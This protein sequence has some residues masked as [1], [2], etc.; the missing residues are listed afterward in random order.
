ML[1]GSDRMLTLAISRR[2]CRRGG[3]TLQSNAAREDRVRELGGGSVYDPAGTVQHEFHG[4]EIGQTETAPNLD[5]PRRDQARRD[6]GD[7]KP[8]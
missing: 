2:N 5:E 3:M 1:R 8:S 7:A 6:D 4:T